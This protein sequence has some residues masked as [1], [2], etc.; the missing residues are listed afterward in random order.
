MLSIVLLVLTNSRR[1]R[2]LI[3]SLVSLAISAS[4]ITYLELSVANEPTC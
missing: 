1:S 4:R 3:L 2:N